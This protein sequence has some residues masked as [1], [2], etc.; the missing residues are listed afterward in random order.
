MVLRFINST[1]RLKTLSSTPK[2][3]AQKALL[4]HYQ[5]AHRQGYIRD[6]RTVRREVAQQ[7][8][9]WG[10][11]HSRESTIVLRGVQTQECISALPDTSERIPK[12]LF[13]LHERFHLTL[14][15]RHSKDQTSQLGLR[16]H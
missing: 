15:L 6:A 9:I 5:I 3:P 14:M 16:D 4:S 10:P 2:H 13:R 12:H 7:L 11:C 1:M 8:A